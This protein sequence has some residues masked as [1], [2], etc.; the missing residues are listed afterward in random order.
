LPLLTFQILK[1]RKLLWIMP[2]KA[3]KYSGIYKYNSELISL[4]K[5]N[6]NISILFT[7]RINNYFFTFW[8]KFFYLPFFLLLNSK[9]FDCIVYPE[10]GFAF[11]SIF[12]SA[13]E[14]KL[15]IHDFRKKFNLKNNVKIIEKIKQFYIDL[16]FLFINNFMKIIVPSVFTKKILSSSIRAISKNII[17]I[18]NIIDFKKILNLKNNKF[19]NLINKKYKIILCV[20]SNETRKNVSLIYQV[21]KKTNKIKFILVGDFNENYKKSNIMVFKNLTEGDLAQLFNIADLYLDLSFFEG[22]G[23][24]LIEAQQFGLPV[25]CFNTLINKEILRSSAYLIDKNYNVDQL[26]NYISSKSAT[27]QKKIASIQNSA[28]YSK[29]SIYKKFKKEIDEI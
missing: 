21:A 18:P 15:I 3:K 8:S 12:S 17:V 29:K 24:T 22:F 23:R 1:M 19:N 14:N 16:N 28:R 4:Q 5:K 13:S 6:K 25:L 10:E 11:L 2:N 26:T 27:P 7:G 9:N 20:S